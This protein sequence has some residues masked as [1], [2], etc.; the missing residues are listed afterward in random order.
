MIPVS[1]ISVLGSRFSKRGARR[2][3]GQ[4]SIGSPSSLTTGPCSS[5]G[6][7]ST[8]RMR[9]SAGF[10]TGTAIAWPVSNTSIP[11]CTPSVEL[12]DTARTWDLPMCC[13][14][15][16]TRSISRPDSVSAVSLSAL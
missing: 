3:I 2:W 11:R 6:S 4:R 13:C 14:T 8:L 5:T 1:K 15:S 9:P 7:P 12:I 16:A 10:P